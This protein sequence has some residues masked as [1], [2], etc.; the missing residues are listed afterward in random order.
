M[1]SFGIYPHVVAALIATAHYGIIP[2]NS[3]ELYPN[4]ES[5]IENREGE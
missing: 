5:G 4:R 3:Q 1:R 2:F